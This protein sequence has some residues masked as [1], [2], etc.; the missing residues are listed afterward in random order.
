M[1]VS[2][3]EA[4]GA[5]RRSTVA[6]DELLRSPIIRIDEHDPIGTMLAEQWSRLGVAPTGGITVQTHHIALVLAEQ[7]F[8][9][10]I[11]DSFTAQAR[12]DAALHVRTL[13]PEIGVEVRALLPQGTRSPRPVGD[14]IRAFK[15]VAAESEAQPG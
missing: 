12:R 4:R 6:L 7:G 10:A 14:F 2:R 13:L 3:V 11:V 5:D 15:A 1:C 9:P 8:G